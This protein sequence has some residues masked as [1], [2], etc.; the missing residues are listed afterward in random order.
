MQ[1]LHAYLCHCHVGPIGP[2]GLHPGPCADGFL[3][4]C[5][6]CGPLGGI[7]LFFPVFFCFLNYLFSFDFCFI[8]LF[9]LLLAQNNY[10]LSV[11]PLVSKFE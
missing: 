11:N 5:R 9:F 4:V 8:F 7:F 2:A 1:A 10:K 6:P 3:V